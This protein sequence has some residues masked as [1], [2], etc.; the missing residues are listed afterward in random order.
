[1][2]DAHVAAIKT[3]WVLSHPSISAVVLTAKP[4]DLKTASAISSRPCCRPRVVGCCG[5]SM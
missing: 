5:I 2:I 4:A 1:L 3:A